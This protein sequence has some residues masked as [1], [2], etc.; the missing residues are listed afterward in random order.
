MLTWKSVS[1][2]I[3]CSNLLDFIITQFNGIINNSQLCFFFVCMFVPSPVRYFEFKPLGNRIKRFIIT[4]L[5]YFFF[6]IKQMKSNMMEKIS[7]CCRVHGIRHCWLRSMVPTQTD[8]MS[9]NCRAHFNFEG[10]P[11]MFSGNSSSIQSRLP[12]KIVF[13]RESS[14]MKG[15]WGLGL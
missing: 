10:R 11:E 13:C 8:E 5:I 1:S 7:F 2:S 9:I 14:S 4:F 3:I 15:W 6:I 12:A